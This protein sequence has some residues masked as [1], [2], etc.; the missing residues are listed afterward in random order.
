MGT[1]GVGYPSMATL[2]PVDRPQPIAGV[3]GDTHHHDPRDS[4][5]TI[6]QDSD[7]PQIRKSLANHMPLGQRRWLVMVS[8][9]WSV[10]VKHE[11]E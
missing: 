10:P 5:I 1:L 9:D 6:R 4:A 7:T 8:G 11:G 3:P 2:N